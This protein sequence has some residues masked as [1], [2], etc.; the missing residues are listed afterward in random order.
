LIH[1]YKRYCNKIY[2]WGLEA[3]ETTSNALT[4]LP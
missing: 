2:G 1:F 4:A 3:S